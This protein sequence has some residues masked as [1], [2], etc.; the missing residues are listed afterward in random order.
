MHTFTPPIRSVHRF[1]STR[2]VPWLLILAGGFLGSIARFIIGEWSSLLTGTLFVNT[3]GSVFMGIFM[4]ESIWLGR[5]SRQTR[6]LW[7][8][9][10][11]GAFTT[12]SSLAV[13]AAELPPA[14]GL[15]YFLVTVACGIM[16]IFAGRHIILYQ[17]GI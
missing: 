16:G 12:F 3:A 14:L 11:L 15:G 10:F 7:G 5:F 2:L 6:L 4:Y 9:G 8:M 13:I 1:V 17:R